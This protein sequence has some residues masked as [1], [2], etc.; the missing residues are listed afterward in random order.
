M[1][2]VFTVIIH[3]TAIY[4]SQYQWLHCYII[5]GLYGYTTMFQRLKRTWPLLLLWLDLIYSFILNIV[6]SISL[7]QTPASQNSL[8]VSPDI[9]FSW[10]QVIANGGMVLT[11][12]FAFSI[13]LQL[14]RAVQQHQSWPMTPVRIS[15]LLIVLAF[16]LPAW[17]QWL[18]AL[19]ALVHGQMVVEWHNLR[20]LIVSI[21]L[22]Y[23]ACLCLR[24]LW[25]RHRQHKNIDDSDNFIQPAGTQPPY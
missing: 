23:P 14:N 9:A 11:L 19:W 15:A 25:I 13:L 12:S 8:P 6:A 1:S 5:I 20:Y 21:L 2:A 18:W 17:W 4:S 16:S 3:L 10:L 22:L 7:E 24:L